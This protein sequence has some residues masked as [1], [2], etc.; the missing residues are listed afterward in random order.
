MISFIVLTYKKN[1]FSIV[2]EINQFSKGSDLV[3]ERRP[4]AK[5]K[6][7]KEEEMR[8]LC[9]KDASDEKLK[10]FYSDTLK[11]TDHLEDLGVHRRITLK[12][13]EE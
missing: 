4:A 10:L 12:H 7:N 1:T 2:K 5:E 9:T 3:K 6:E 8:E 13:I 11:G